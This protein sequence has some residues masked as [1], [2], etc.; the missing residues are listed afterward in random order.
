MF[1]KLYDQNSSQGNVNAGSNSQFFFQASSRNHV[2]N[3]HF[4]ATLF[5]DEIRTTTIFDP[6]KSRNQLGFNIGASVTDLGVK[7]LTLGAEY[8]RINPF[9]YQNFIPAEDYTNH[10]YPLGDWMGANADRLIGYI[11]Y[12]PIP[13][14]KT[15]LLVQNTRKGDPGSLLDQY[16][17]EPQP[18]FLDSYIFQQTTFQLK[19]SYEWLN[20][21]YFEGMIQTQNEKY[22][23]TIPDRNFKE[24][25]IGMKVGI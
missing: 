21:L 9:V 18:K 17:A 2:K 3:T 22:V 23:S 4:Y 8:T 12:T 20:N 13:R 7:Y 5:I 14:L 1:F 16:F 10:G 24:V 19:L 25:R 6:E 11:K 15:T